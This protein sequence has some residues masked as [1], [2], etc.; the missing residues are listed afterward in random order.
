MGWP[1]PEQLALRYSIDYRL[2]EAW[3]AVLD[4]FAAVVHHVTPKAFCYAVDAQPSALSHALKGSERHHIQGR[5]LVYAIA[6][7]PNK[8]LAD[9]LLAMASLRA[10]SL[11]KSAEQRVLELETFIRRNAIVE[12]AAKDEGVL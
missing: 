7:A 10:E 6:V 9:A 3:S 8:R 4:E 2:E 5:W 1:V 11:P 12:R